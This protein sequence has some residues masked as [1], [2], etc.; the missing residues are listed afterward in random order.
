[1]RSPLCI[2]GIPRSGFSLVISLLNEAFDLDN[3]GYREIQQVDKEAGRILFSRF[4]ERFSD[5]VSWSGEFSRLSGGPKQIDSRDNLWLRKYIGIKGSGDIVFSIRVPNYIHAFIPIY[6]SHFVDAASSNSFSKLNVF[7]YRHPCGIYES[8]INSINALASHYIQNDL[9]INPSQQETVRQQLALHKVTSPIIREAMIKFMHDSQRD[10]SAYMENMPVEAIEK[11]LWE[12]IISLRTRA[13]ESLSRVCQ[14]FGADI[15]AEEIREIVFR[16][17]YRNLLE[18]HKH[19]FR[20]GHAVIAGW[21]QNLPESVQQQILRDPVSKTMMTSFNVED[22]YHELVNQEKL[23]APFKKLAQ[24]CLDNDYVYI[25]KIDETLYEFA[26]NKTNVDQ[27]FF[28]ESYLVDIQYTNV[29]IHRMSKSLEYLTESLK[30]LSER[31]EILWD[32]ESKIGPISENEAFPSLSQPS[33]VCLKML[34][35]LKEY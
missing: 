29:K 25:P 1:M 32:I 7:T 4:I 2:Y 6:H 30:D 11:V 12:D 28:K 9:S 14:R 13:I 31:L 16:S 35:L 34:S 15:A 24:A 26:L 23:G 33:K 19:N 17:R 22:H 20:P 5:H 18:A 10:M 27:S 3:S 21:R 8:A